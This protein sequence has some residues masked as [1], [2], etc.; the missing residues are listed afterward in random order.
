MCK[1]QKDCYTR[2]SG[3]VRRPKQANACSPSHAEN[4]YRIMYVSNLRRVSATPRYGVPLRPR[5]ARPLLPLPAPATH[6]RTT[7][8]RRISDQPKST[9]TT[10][11]EGAEAAWQ[12]ASAKLK[13]WAKVP[14]A[15]TVAGAVALVP[16]VGGAWLVT[17]Y[18]LRQ[19]L[20]E[21]R[22]QQVYMPSCGS[23][24]YLLDFSWQSSLA[25]TLLL[26]YDSCRH[27]LLVH[28]STYQYL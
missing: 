24:Q 3:S 18:A 14:S 17:V 26:Q 11:V 23:L 19:Q 7:T 22:L 15:S 8:V 20:C 27:C 28:F 16:V 25:L 5:V 9:S 12:S 6:G 1:V 13:D 10:V 4:P 2:I 21:H